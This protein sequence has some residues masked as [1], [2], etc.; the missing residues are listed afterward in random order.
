MTVFS[1]RGSDPP[2][3]M[4]ISSSSEDDGLET[5]PDS[6]ALL[7]L[8]VGHLLLDLGQSLLCSRQRSAL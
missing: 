6:R 2:Q 1:Y 8:E 3:T 7:L 5:H 4:S